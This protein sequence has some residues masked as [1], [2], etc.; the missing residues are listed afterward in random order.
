[1]YSSGSSVQPPS[2]QAAVV[3]VQVRNLILVSFEQ[4][5]RAR[6]VVHALL[7]NVSFFRNDQSFSILA[8]V[9]RLMPSRAEKPVR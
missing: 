9:H 8:K 7:V 3:V 4:G 2:E 1:M 6:L 5:L